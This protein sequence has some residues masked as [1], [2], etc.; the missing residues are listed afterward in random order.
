[1]WNFRSGGLPAYLKTLEDSLENNYQGWK[2]EK[3]R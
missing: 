2:I 3:A 1:M